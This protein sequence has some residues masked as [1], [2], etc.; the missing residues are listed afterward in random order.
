MIE[1]ESIPKLRFS[2]FNKQWEKNVLSAVTKIYDGT[3]QT[4]KYVKE[5][6]PFYSVEHVTSNNFENTKFISHEVFVK[7]NKRVQLEKNDILLTRIG[8][9]GECRLIDWDLKASFYVSLAL[10]KHNSF[11]NSSYLS[12]YIKSPVFQKE[13]WKRMLHIAFPKKINLGEI[14][15]CNV[16]HTSLEEQKKIAEFLSAVDKKIELL[17][18]NKELMSQY[19]KGIMQ[20]IF[21]QEIRFKDD[22]GKPFPDWQEKALGTF[23]ERITNKNKIGEGNVLTISGQDGLINQEKYFNKSVASKDLSNYTILNKNDFAYNKS[24]SK[25]YP[26]GAIKR[27]KNYETGVVSPLYIC[28]SVDCEQVNLCF[29]EQLIENGDLNKWIHKI[30]Q[31]GARNHGL[32]NVS[33]KEFFSDIKLRLPHPDEQKKIAEFLTSL[34]TK[35]RTSQKNSKLTKTSKK[36]CSS[37]CLSNK[38][39]IE[40]GQ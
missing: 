38:G 39:I 34:D 3:H 15:K 28:F 12:Q 2:G 20:K 21:S 19:K 8:S 1:I 29:F 32:L 37:R 6:I 17:R 26:M 35:L 40:N 30:A 14:G 36:P 31:E 5:G 9:V 10:I 11:I 16:S 24:Y 18:K 27:L 23:S 33:V 22:Q 7:E 13:I 25:G 4:P